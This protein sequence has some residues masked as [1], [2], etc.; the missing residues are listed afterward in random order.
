MKTAEEVFEFYS[1]EI[2]LAYES[3]GMGIVKYRNKILTIDRFKQA[4]EAY[5][6]ERKASDEEI[7]KEAHKYAKQFWEWENDEKESI[8]FF[9]YVNG[10]KSRNTK[11]IAIKSPEWISVEKQLPQE[12]QQV[13]A[14]CEKYNT[15]FD[16]F[17]TKGNFVFSDQVIYKTTTEVTHWQELPKAPA[18][19]AHDQ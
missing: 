10:M 7:E 13:L 8:A 6:Q 17:F 12:G 14:F 16:A 18:L 3:G 15:M 2:T 9:A 5:L 11:S 19:Q 1:E 4:M